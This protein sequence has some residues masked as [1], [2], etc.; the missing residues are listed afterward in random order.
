MSIVDN[1]VE[2]IKQHFILKNKGKISLFDRKRVEYSMRGAGE[3]FH[4]LKE[5]PV[6]YDQEKAAKLNRSIDRLIENKLNS[7]VLLMELKTTINGGYISGYALKT[8]RDISEK[9]NTSEAD[10]V[11]KIADLVNGQ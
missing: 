7:V 8:I 3:P 6:K 4:E 5:P 2:A 1:A 11:Q 10:D 9:I